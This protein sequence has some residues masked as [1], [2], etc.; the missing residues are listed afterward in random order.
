MNTWKKRRD[1][2]ASKDGVSKLLTLKK[3]TKNKRILLKSITSLILTNM[4]TLDYTA[5]HWSNA[6]APVTKKCSAALFRQVK[7]I[8]NALRRFWLVN[9][10]TN[11]M[12]HAL[13]SNTLA[14]Q[15]RPPAFLIR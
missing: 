3:D 14:N 2:G 4:I 15:K 8:K 1:N 12:L 10:N 11:E 6:P 9:E 5:N 7:L 13:K